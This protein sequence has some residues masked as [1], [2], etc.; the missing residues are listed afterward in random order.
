MSVHVL[1]EP[2]PLWFAVVGVRVGMNFLGVLHS[3]RMVWLRLGDVSGWCAEWAVPIVICCWW[4]E[5][6]RRREIRFFCVPAVMAWVLGR[7]REIRPP[8][9]QYI[10]VD[11]HKYPAGLFTVPRKHIIFYFAMA[12]PS[13]WTWNWYHRFFRF[14]AFF[15]VIHNPHSVLWPTTMR[16]QTTSFSRA[17]FFHSLASHSRKVCT[18]AVHSVALWTRVT[19]QVWTCVKYVPKQSIP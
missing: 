1:N 18:E 10:N 2:C 7:W 11:I 5:F 19:L 16:T 14:F 8:H 13:F 4:C 9:I 6:W 12:K 3:V 17:T 15:C